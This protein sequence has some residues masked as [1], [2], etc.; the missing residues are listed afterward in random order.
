M[1]IREFY[2]GSDEQPLDKLVSDGGFTGIFRKIGAV[3]DSLSSGEFE[4]VSETGEK[5]YHDCFDFSW[6]QYIA[7]IAGTNV[8]NMSRGGMTARE[9]CQSFADRYGYFAA[10]KACGAY[11]IALAVNDWNTD[12]EI[13]SAYDADENDPRSH[14]DT[15]GGW[16]GELIL[17]YKAISPDAKFFLVV[18]PKEEPAQRDQER[19]AKTR[20]VIRDFAERFDNTY[21]IDLY[22]YA[23]VYDAEFR[24][25]FYL[26]GHMNPAGYILT[27]KMFVSYIDFIIRKNPADFRRAGFIK[28]QYN[29]TI[30]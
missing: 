30:L 26:Y 11:I 23:P 27:A 16:Y 6:G 22:E 15:F 25:N 12:I 3:G 4:D 18:P 29:R 7:R 2:A 8:I 1:D 10:D 9:Y 13:G 28:A 24:E 21:I 20:G 19:K 14:P 5:S 17:R